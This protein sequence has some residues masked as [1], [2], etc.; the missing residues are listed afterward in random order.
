MAHKMKKEVVANNYVNESSTDVNVW[1]RY[2]THKGRPVYG[3]VKGSKPCELWTCESQNKRVSIS[4]CSNETLPEHCEWAEGEE[5][6]M[7]PHC[8]PRK[9]CEEEYT[10]LL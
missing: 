6:N 10:R 7:F 2:C 3:T 5:D 1:E 9:K 4:K 8:C